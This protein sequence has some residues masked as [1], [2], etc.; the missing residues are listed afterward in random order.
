MTKRK[1]RLSAEA[2]QD[3]AAIGDGI[4]QYSPRRAAKFTDDIGVEFELLREMPDRF[5]KVRRH[6][7]LRRKV[8]GNY[9]IFYRASDAAVDI[10]H[11]IHGAMDYER[12]LFPEDSGES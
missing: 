12:I 7:N 1:V 6:E 3:I 10:V 9:L 11:V 2:I 4:S 8:F 5:A